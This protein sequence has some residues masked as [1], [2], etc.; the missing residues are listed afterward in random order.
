MKNKMRCQRRTAKQLETNSRV[1]AMTCASRATT[2]RIVRPRRASI[3]LGRVRFSSSPCPSRPWRP[4]PHE[5]STPVPVMSRRNRLK[6][7]N[8]PFRAYT[9]RVVLLNRLPAIAYELL[10]PAAISFIATVS[11]ARTIAGSPRFSKLS[12]PN[13]PLEPSPTEYKAPNSFQI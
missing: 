10:K 11:R 13:C 12:C 8:N 3:T 1:A 5:Y 2:L 4:Q 6:K 9:R 7:I